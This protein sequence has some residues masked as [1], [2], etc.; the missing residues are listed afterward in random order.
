SPSRGVRFGRGVEIG[1]ITSRGGGGYVVPLDLGEDFGEE[2][3]VC[4]GEEGEE[5][6]C[7]VGEGEERD[8]KEEREMEDIKA[9]IQSH[10]TSLSCDSR[11]LKLVHVGRLSP[12]K[13]PTYLLSSFGHLVRTMKKDAVLFIV[14]TGNI[15]PSLQRAAMSILGPSLYARVIWTGAVPRRLVPAVLEGM[16]AFVNPNLNPDETFCL[17]NVEGM[18]KGLPLV[19][20]GYGGVGDYLVDGVNGVRVEGIGVEE[21][22]EGMWVE[23]WKG[24]GG[25]GV[26]R[27]YGG[28]KQGREIEGIF[29]ERIAAAAKGGKREGERTCEVSRVKYGKVAFWERGGRNATAEVAVECGGMDIGCGEATSFAVCGEDGTCRGRV[30][31]ALR[32]ACKGREGGRGVA[33][34]E[35]GEDCFRIEVDLT[36]VG[37]GVEGI[38]LCPWDDD[39]DGMVTGWCERFGLEDE[40]CREVMQYIGGTL[41]WSR[42][43][44]WVGGM[45]RSAGEDW[46]DLCSGPSLSLP[47]VDGRSLDFHVGLI[48]NEQNRTLI[49]TPSRTSISVVTPTWLKSAEGLWFEVDGL[50]NGCIGYDGVKLLAM[51]Y[52]VETDTPIEGTML[53]RL[54]KNLHEDLLGGSSGG[55]GKNGGNA[56]NSSTHGIRRNH[57][58]NSMSSP[59]R[60]PYGQPSLRRPAGGRQNPAYTLVTL[61][62]FKKYCISSGLTSQDLD[63]VR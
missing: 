16:D 14:G 1:R 27:C 32:G 31:E 15:L 48:V 54:T 60:S 21:F 33:E 2:E 57:S 41:Q 17:A 11:C 23:G 53:S 61:S 43:S 46:M 50:G 34:V 4:K 42:N 45:V 40:V 13:H 56:N 18:G 8:E 20:H 30:E 62:K 55:G 24:R 22:G 12:E 6:E 47:A 38:T 19:S 35:L 9:A 63:G 37:H 10:L 26:R 36:G 59:R 25:E 39:L 51:L 5:K 52:F 28:D 7:K 44:V 58:F 29:R 49:S 3:R